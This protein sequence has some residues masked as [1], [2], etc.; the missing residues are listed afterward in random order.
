M[1]TKIVKP[2]TN[3]IR[4]T[5]IGEQTD[6]LLFGMLIYRKKQYSRETE[7]LSLKEFKEQIKNVL[8]DA[9]TDA[10]RLSSI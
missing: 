6:I 5:R 9:V 7:S 1:I 2:L 10:N 8:L 4:T 3:T